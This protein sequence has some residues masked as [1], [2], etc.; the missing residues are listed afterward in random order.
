MRRARPWMQEGQVVARRVVG[1]YSGTV[2]AIRRELTVVLL[3]RHCACLEDTMDGLTASEVVEGAASPERPAE[4]VAYPHL[5]FDDRGRPWIDD[6]NTKVIE[7][8]LD[9]TAYAMSAQ[10]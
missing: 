8:V 1:G 5:W 9:H 10:E 7:V 2:I 3:T 6:T 4:P